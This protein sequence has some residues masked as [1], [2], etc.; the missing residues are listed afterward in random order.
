MRRTAVFTAVLSVLLPAASFAQAIIAQ[1]FG[2]ASPQH[3]IDFG[4]NLY[5]NF[6][7]V[8]TEFAGI[9][10]THTKYF[11]TGT[12]VNLAGG[13]LTNDFSG[14]PNTLKIKFASPIHDLSFVYQ[15][16]GQSNPSV[17]RAMLGPVTVDTFSLLWNSSLSNNYFGFTNVVFDELQIDFDS[18]FN[19][20]TLAF[21]DASAAPQP[22][23]TAGTTTHGCLASITAS[24]NPSV[25]QAH[26]CTLAVANVEGQ[27]SGILFYGINNTGFSGSPWGAGGTSYLCVKAP[28][29]RTPLQNSGGTVDLCNGSFALDWNAYQSANPAAL[30]HPWSAGQKVYAQG[31]FRDP[32]AV[33][34]TNLSNAVEMTYVP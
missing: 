16:V 9:T 30:G 15:Q 10:L 32:P 6:T 4:A 19:L 18:D 14:L 20:D 33:R 34:A 24:A 21:N 26:G 29:Q 11:T 31:W 17:F 25:S 23:C 1:P 27:K 22:Y 5:P 3:V 8:T 7:P 28:L 2:L 12:Y 13:F